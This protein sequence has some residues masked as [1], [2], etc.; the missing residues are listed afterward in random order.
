MHSTEV[1]TVLRPLRSARRY[2]LPAAPSVLL[3][4]ANDLHD[5]RDLILSGHTRLLTLV[6]PP[7][8]GKTRL[9]LAIAEALEDEFE[10]GAA[11][12]DLSSVRDSQL[13]LEAVAHAF[14]L[15]QQ[16]TSKPADQLDVYLRD[17]SLLLVLDNFEHVPRR[18]R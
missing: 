10:Q 2:Q 9:A 15:R 17:A 14:G 8:V 11:F 16:G 12:V 7:G 13:V 4:R 18:E 3:G 5:A 6:G 1:V